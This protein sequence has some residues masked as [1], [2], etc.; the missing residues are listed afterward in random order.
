MIPLALSDE[1]CVGVTKGNGVDFDVQKSH[2]SRIAK[3]SDCVVEYQNNICLNAIFPV[4]MDI[5]HLPSF[6]NLNWSKIPFTKIITYFYL[7]LLHKVLYI[8]VISLE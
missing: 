8:S 4:S 2:M 3:M 1:G 6:H 5:Y 7:L